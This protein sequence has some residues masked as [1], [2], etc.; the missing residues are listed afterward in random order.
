MLLLLPLSA[1]RRSS[2]CC[3]LL[4][5]TA[6]Y[7]ILPRVFLV[8]LFP[9]FFLVFLCTFST[10]NIRAIPAL[11]LKASEERKCRR[12]EPFDRFSL[13]GLDLSLL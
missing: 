5:P 3:F 4:L 11:P 1:S 9:L 6:R 12:A 8:S 2:I 10:T 7:S 13:T